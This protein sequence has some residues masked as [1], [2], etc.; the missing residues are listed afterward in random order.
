MPRQVASRQDIGEQ[1]R[2][3]RGDAIVADGIAKQGFIASDGGQVLLSVWEGLLE[4]A[5]VS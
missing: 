5:V 3:C 2:S 1:R 4:V